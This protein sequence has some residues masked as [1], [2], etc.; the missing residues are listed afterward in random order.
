MRQACSVLTD[1]NCFPAS[2][3]NSVT[4]AGAVKAALAISGSS[5]LPVATVQGLN[6]AIGLPNQPHVISRQS[7]TPR[8]AQMGRGFR[9]GLKSLLSDS[10]D[11]CNMSGSFLSRQCF[12]KILALDGSVSINFFKFK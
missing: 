1:A 12:C 5:S 6:L 2:L 8:R 9:G 11:L 10:N 7:S 3:N 4:Y